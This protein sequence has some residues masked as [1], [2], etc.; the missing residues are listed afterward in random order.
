MYFPPYVWI[1]IKNFMFQEYWIKTYKQVVRRL[2]RYQNHAT[3]KEGAYYYP[4][5]RLMHYYNNYQLV[6][7]KTDIVR[8]YKRFRPFKNIRSYSLLQGLLKVYSVYDARY[9]L[10]NPQ[11]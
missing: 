9:P 6:Y 2:P 8:E 11:C 3:R 1:S 7:P 10:Y 5:Q 4:P